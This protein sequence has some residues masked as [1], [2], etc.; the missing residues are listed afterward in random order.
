[1]VRLRPPDNLTRALTWSRPAEEP[2]GSRRGAAHPPPEL[3]F[4]RARRET[5]AALGRG[6]ARTTSGLG[7]SVETRTLKG[8][9]SLVQ[10]SRRQREKPRCLVSA[11]P[12]SP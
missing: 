4:T 6:S 5:R 9:R 8:L 11:L 7:K 10:T 2:D 12:P 1:M 3:A